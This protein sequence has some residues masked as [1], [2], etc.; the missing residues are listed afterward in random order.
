MTETLIGG[1]W[2]DTVLS[3]SWIFEQIESIDAV[4][5]WRTS[6]PPD[7]RLTFGRKP[8]YPIDD[9]LWKRRRLT[10]LAECLMIFEGFEDREKVIY[11]MLTHR[12]AKRS[13]S[14]RFT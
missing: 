4:I 8:K 2:Q 9:L 5:K 6:P 12:I 7:S 10:D 1:V 3:T 11:R 14:P 13:R